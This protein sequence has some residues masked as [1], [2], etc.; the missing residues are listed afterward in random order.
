MARARERA[1]TC[2]EKV[3]CRRCAC[4]RARVCGHLSA[5]RVYIETVH[6]EPNNDRV[7]KCEVQ[8][9]GDAGKEVRRRGG[10]GGEGDVHSKQTCTMCGGTRDQSGNIATR[11]APAAPQRRAA[12]RRAPRARLFIYLCSRVLD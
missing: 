3:R 12:P 9:R 2:T 6:C 8:G 4:V 7:A 5:H 1:H 11:E 10:G